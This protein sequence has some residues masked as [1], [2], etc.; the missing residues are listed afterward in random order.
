MF[1]PTP[2]E[3]AGDWADQAVDFGGLSYD[4]FFNPRSLGYR[5]RPIPRKP[6][7]VAYGQKCACPSCRSEGWYA[8]S[9]LCKFWRATCE[10]CGGERR[11]W[12]H[13]SRT[14]E[15]CEL[16]QEEW[17]LD[18]RFFRDALRSPRAVA[19][20]LRE[21]AASAAAQA[22]AEARARAEAEERLRAARWFAH[23]PEHERARLTRLLTLPIGAHARTMAGRNDE[24][25]CWLISVNEW[26]VFRW[27][28]GSIYRMND[29][30]PWHRWFQDGRSPAEAL[31]EA[32]KMRT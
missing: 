11:F 3:L 15:P 22:Q 13:A 18:V 20:R 1:T 27:D 19:R 28:T 21:Q 9:P 6:P 16:C 32:I 14:Y 26:S 31:A 30:I 10:V 2:A 8:V 5:G 4:A 17:T 25:A 24:F 23:Q 29:D 12:V 7:P